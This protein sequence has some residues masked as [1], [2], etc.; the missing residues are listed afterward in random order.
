MITAKF[1]SK[2]F[3]VSKS[4]IYTPNGITYTD[5]IELEETEV[6]KK[7]PKVTLKSK[8][9]REISFDLLLDVRFVNVE[10]EIK[11]WDNLLNKA[12]AQTFTL[13]KMNLGKFFLTKVS[14]S[15][16]V[17]IKTGQLTQAKLSL[18][19]KEKP[20]SSTS[21]SSSSS[22]S[23]NIKVGTKIKPKSGTRWYYTA[24]G[25]INRTGISGSAYQKTMTVTYI[26][27]NGQA[28]NPQGLGWMIPADVDVVS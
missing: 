27:N 2:S 19:F 26:Y 10:T 5:S 24:V 28:I 8:G 11:A 14:K 12:T 23:K 21:S 15:D 25:A 13:G 18:S 1:G 17:M 22:S 3:E 9:L 4:K 6:S 7:K 20:S 16:F